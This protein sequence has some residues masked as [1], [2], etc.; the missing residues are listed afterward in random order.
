MCKPPR[1]P[2]VFVVLLVR[3]IDFF[4]A[5]PLQFRAHR[6]LLLL[7]LLALMLLL[8]PGRLGQLQQSEKHALQP[9]IIAKKISQKRPGP[10]QIIATVRV[11]PP[12]PSPR[13]IAKVGLL[14]ASTDTCGPI[15]DVSRCTLEETILGIGQGNK[16]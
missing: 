1:Q 15:F 7:L 14:P 13:I 4:A 9:Q 10:T 12:H 11:G 2:F 3:L 8:L 6:L 16:D 5:K